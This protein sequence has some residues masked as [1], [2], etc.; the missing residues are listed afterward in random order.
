[1]DLGT[2]ALES[3]HKDDKKHFQVL[4][5]HPQDIL[6]GVLKDAQAKRD[7]ARKKQ[8]R[9]VKSNGSIIVL[10]DVF[11]RI[12]NS[13]S[14]CGRCRQFS[15]IIRSPTLGSHPFTASGELALQCHRVRQG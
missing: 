10:R 7:S 5:S 4:Q 8:W 15:T 12:V 6:S 11:E 2:K 13:I 3:L 9:F 1:M 14:S